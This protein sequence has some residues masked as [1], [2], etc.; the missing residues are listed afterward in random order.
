M[1]LIPEL[2]FVVWG[3]VELASV[4]GRVNGD[5]GGGPLEIE[6]LTDRVTFSAF[7]YLNLCC[8]SFWKDFL[9]LSMS[10]ILAT[11]VDIYCSKGYLFY[12]TIWL[13]FEPNY[14]LL[15]LTMLDTYCLVLIYENLW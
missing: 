7:S 9:F 10:I 14:S 12:P 2:G 5:I 15:G 3:V 6:S 1:R 11:L 4:L 13:I 8:K